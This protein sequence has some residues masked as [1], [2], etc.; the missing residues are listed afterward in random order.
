MVVLKKHLADDAKDRALAHTSPGPVLRHAVPVVLVG[1][2]IDHEHAA[3]VL[4]RFRRAQ[5]N[6]QGLGFVVFGNN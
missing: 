4:E 3:V 6:D 2:A 5:N 1:L